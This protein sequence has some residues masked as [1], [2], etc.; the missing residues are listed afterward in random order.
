MS[1]IPDATL[2]GVIAGMQTCGLDTNDEEIVK[3]THT[4]LAVNLTST[5]LAVSLW[6]EATEDAR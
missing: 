2:R 5:I 4:G 3:L 6:T 1:N